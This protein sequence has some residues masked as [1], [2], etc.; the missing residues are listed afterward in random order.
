MATTKNTLLNLCIHEV[1]VDEAM[2][3][4]EGNFIPLAGFGNHSYLRTAA[5]LD[6]DAA[7]IAGGVADGNLQ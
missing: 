5:Q 1:L 2:H 7:V 3:T 4:L 6:N